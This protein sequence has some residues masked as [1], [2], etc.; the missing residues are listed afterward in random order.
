MDKPE[1]NYSFSCE[2]LPNGEVEMSLSSDGERIGEI[3]M[4]ADKIGDVVLAILSAAMAAGKLAGTSQA[5]KSGEALFDVPTVFPT[6]LGLVQGKLLN[7][8]ALMLQFG[9][10]RLAV[11]MADKEL[12][13]L[14]Q[15]LGTLTNPFSS[16]Q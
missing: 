5:P 16:Q 13:A 2:A 11:R 7:S 12:A 14:G 6:G 1:Q 3:K 10:A 9:P 4:P 8:S 15:A